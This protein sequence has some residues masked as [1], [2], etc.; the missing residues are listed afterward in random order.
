M[1]CNFSYAPYYVSVFELEKPRCT[2]F[3]YYRVPVK[4]PKSELSL[5]RFC[6]TGELYNEAGE[7]ATAAMKGRL[8]NKY[9]ALAEEAWAE[10][11]E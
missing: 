7:A 3:Q 6:F 2:Y 9:Y 10:I 5:I 1:S 8:A 4:A 11:E